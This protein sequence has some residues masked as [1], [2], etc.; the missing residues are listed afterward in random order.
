MKYIKLFE[1]FDRG[2]IQKLS[3]KQLAIY[4]SYIKENYPYINV[5]LDLRPLEYDGISFYLNDIE[6]KTFDDIIVN[7]F[8]YILQHLDIKNYTIKDGLID[9]D[10]S[11]DISKKRLSIIPISFGHIKGD[12]SCKDNHITSLKGSPIS[13]SGCF[14]CR[15]NKLTNLEYLPKKIG[16]S[17]YC[18]GNPDL[19]DLSHLPE[20]YRNKIEVTVWANQYRR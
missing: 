19:K 6:F 14:D 8:N 13:V 15:N 11:V 16:L 2:G 9:V 20:H 17:I 3:S 12:F 18:E 5:D 4:D 10:S 1:N 7:Q